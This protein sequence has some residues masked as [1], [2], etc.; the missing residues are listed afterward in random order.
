MVSGVQYNIIWGS[1]KEEEVLSGSLFC[2]SWGRG[3]EKKF[4]QRRRRIYLGG[5]GPCFGASL[6][7]FSML[8]WGSITDA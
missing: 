8:L 2:A 3:E 1:K 5:F 6:S 7:D 4:F